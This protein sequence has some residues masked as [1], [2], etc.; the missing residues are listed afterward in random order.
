[1][2]M[3]TGQMS[4]LETPIRLTN[5]LPGTQ[6]PLMA[7]PESSPTTPR[8]TVSQEASFKLVSS[9]Q[10]F[11]T[12]RITRSTGTL[13]TRRFHA[14]SESQNIMECD[15]YLSKKYNIYFNEF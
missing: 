2:L 15:F 13:T 7:K 9:E 1:M 11:P 6:S 3:A 5:R 14:L 8:V 4:P 10:S 12:I